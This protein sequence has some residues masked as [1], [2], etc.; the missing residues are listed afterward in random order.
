MTSLCS[1]ESCGNDNCSRLGIHIWLCVVSTSVVLVYSDESCSN[2]PIQL[3]I[4]EQLACEGAEFPVCDQKHIT[5]RSLFQTHRCIEDVDGFVALQYD[6]TPYVMVEEYA[7]VT[8][9]ETLSRVVVYRA[10]GLC[11]YS[12]ADGTSFNILLNVGGLIIFATYPTT[13]CNDFN[14]ELL[15]IGPSTLNRCT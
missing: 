7:D 13:S 2:T 8:S 11:Y 4:N 1:F 6:R 10:N 3:V 15:A 9:C 14:T 5:G 12:I